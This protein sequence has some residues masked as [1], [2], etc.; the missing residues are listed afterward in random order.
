[1]PPAFVLSQDQTLRKIK[2]FY[3]KIRF[4]A[5]K[6]FRLE[7]NFVLLWIFKVYIALFNF[8]SARSHLASDRNI[9]YHSFLVL[10]IVFWI[11]F[12]FFSN[13]KFFK[14]CDPQNFSVL[15]QPRCIVAFDAQQ[16][17][18]ISSNFFFASAILNFFSI[19]SG[20]SGEIR[21]NRGKMAE[22]GGVNSGDKTGGRLAL[23]RV[24]RGA[25]Q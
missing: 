5:L 7:I 2:L 15:Y 22:N 14:N 20:F 19:F 13:R 18:N 16:E 3:R 11:F 8:Q 4:K 17:H 12:D 1:M 21:G 25:K 10:Q 24:P 23:C 9:I 6:Y